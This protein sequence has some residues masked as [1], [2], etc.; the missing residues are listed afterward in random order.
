[1]KIGVG[2]RYIA[3]NSEEDKETGYYPPVGTCGTV[4][5]IDDV[6]IRVKWDSGTKGEGIWWCG[7]KDVEAVNE[8]YDE[9]TD[10]I[11]R[12]FEKDEQN[13][14]ALKNC[15]LVDDKSNDLRRLLQKALKM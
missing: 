6:G 12:F 3:I 13:W 14:S 5:D 15:W 11:A 7:F 10:K 4:V 1:M 8:E 2:V 9:L